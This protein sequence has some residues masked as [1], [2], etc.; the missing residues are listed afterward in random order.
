MGNSIY[1]G[2]LINYIKKDSK[3]VKTYPSEQYP[4]E[5]NEGNQVSVELL[6][7]R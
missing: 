1:T 3:T 6:G 5:N 7:R 2:T 4:E